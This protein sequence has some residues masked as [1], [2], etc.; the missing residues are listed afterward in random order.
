MTSLRP[1]TCFF[2]WLCV[3]APSLAQVNDLKPIRI[4]LDSALKHIETTF[5]VYV[6]YSGQWSQDSVTT[7]FLEETSPEVALRTLLFGTGLTYHPF[8]PDAGEKPTFSI[9]NGKR[10]AGM[11]RGHV[12][13]HDRKPIEGVS[14]GSLLTGTQTMTDAEGYYEIPSLPEDTLTFWYRVYQSTQCVPVSNLDNEIDVRMAAAAN[15]STQIGDSLSDLQRTTPDAA[16]HAVNLNTKRLT[17]SVKAGGRNFRVDHIEDLPAVS[18]LGEEDALRAMASLPGVAMTGESVGN[19]NIRGGEGDQNLLLY[20]GI[21]IYF[22][23]HMFGTVG[24]FNNKAISHVD[25]QPGNFS[26]RYGRRVSGV[27][28]AQGRPGDPHELEPSFVYG[29]NLL[30]MSMG[31]ELPIKFGEGKRPLALMVALRRSFSDLW[32]S[33]TASNVLGSHLSASTVADEQ[34]F[35]PDTS[36]LQRTIAEP[37]FFFWDINAKLAWAVAPG[38]QVSVTAFR[39][40]DRLAYRVSRANQGLSDSHLENL[41]LENQGLSLMWN[42]RWRV[43]GLPEAFHPTSQTTLAISR[44][45]NQ[46]T[47][48]LNSPRYQFN[49][50]NFN[51]IQEAVL[52]HRITWQID[53]THEVEV[54]GEWS[55]LALGQSLRTDRLPSNSETGD[56]VRTSTG[57]LYSHY[58][59]YR[60]SYP[61][62]LH[63]DGFWQAT[64]GLRH[65]YFTNNQRHYWEP[66]VELARVI[67]PGLKLQATWGRYYQFVRQLRANYDVNVGEDIFALAETPGEAAVPVLEATQ[68]SLGGS[69][70]N[71]NTT[72]AGIWLFSL[73]GYLKYYQ[74][75]AMYSFANE[76]VLDGDEPN[77]IVPNGSGW[78]RGLDAMVKYEGNW[79]EGWVSYSL[80][81]AVNQFD[82]INRG[83]PFAA[84]TD[85]RHQFSVVSKWSILQSR[86]VFSTNWTFASG[87]PYTPLLDYREDGFLPELSYA[88]INSG[89]LP[90]Y[91]R[92]DL[93][94]HYNHE[95]KA[96]QS[97]AIP[98]VTG[99]I[100]VV[101]FNVYNR[102]NLTQRR[103]RI[104]PGSQRAD[105]QPVP[106]SI[107]QRLLGFSPNIFITLEF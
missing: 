12:M 102:V 1:F 36:I 87:R 106:L 21:P 27:I 53:S 71:G 41:Q 50:E 63:E 26:A 10:K 39:A 73:D 69:Y 24:L 59:Q 88:P 77:L 94:L 99:K 16:D 30:S 104:I 17:L 74:G 22:S 42:S 55:Q 47:Y 70:G 4:S 68:W 86:L 15:S 32:Y 3:S 8:Y 2:L 33:P 48:Q 13:T 67:T 90:D 101:F 25:A 79:L 61:R 5:D 65:T 91:H 103:Y 35:L 45:D 66:R 56:S 93:S 75:L 60:F 80:S 58:G 51:Q 96:M 84:R 14:V 31:T 62:D 100:G 44:Y 6:N 49:R 7:E 107:D 85:Q 98:P 83:L 76:W 34:R 20:D 57:G 92:L 81:Q 82:Q 64:L 105:N 89:R 38:Q 23:Q 43:A 54:G 11:V 9:R 78:V 97:R 19:V 95:F 18:A 37:R 46:Y 28:E 29:A 40:A 52:R 72:E